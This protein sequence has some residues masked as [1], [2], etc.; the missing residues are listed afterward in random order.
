MKGLLQILI[1]WT[2]GSLI[3]RLT[4]GVIPGNII[5]MVLL[6]AGLRRGWFDAA[7]VR[8]A[9]EWLLGTMALFFVPFGVG[10]VESWQQV[11]DNLCAIVVATV[12]STVIVLF[13]A[14]HLFQYFNSGKRPRK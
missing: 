8:P 12:L 4:G 3:S 10:L 13:T 2:A 14:G 11:A 9:A 1:C 5:G 7:A 6:F